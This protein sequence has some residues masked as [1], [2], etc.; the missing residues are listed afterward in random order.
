MAGWTCE[1]GLASWN[2]ACKRLA[3]KLQRSLINNVGMSAWKTR[4]PWNLCISVRMDISS[5]LIYIRQSNPIRPHPI[6]SGRV[7]PNQTQSHPI[8]FSMIK[9][10]RIQSNLICLSTYLGRPVGIW[11]VFM[12]NYTCVY[13][14]IYT[15]MYIICNSMCV[16]VLQ[17]LQ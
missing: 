7:P 17:V 3:A 14:Y 8:Q 12:S 6:Q 9:S 11:C 5:N 1:N 4:P 10:N 15:Y 2:W 13:I 16:S